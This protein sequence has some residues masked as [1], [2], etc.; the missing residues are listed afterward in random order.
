VASQLA[1]PRWYSAVTREGAVVVDV[2]VAEAEAGAAGNTVAVAAGAPGAAD[3][4][5]V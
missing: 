2:D 5:Q 3:H 4:G 1:A